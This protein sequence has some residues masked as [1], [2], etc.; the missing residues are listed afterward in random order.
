M[1][2]KVIALHT[3]DVIRLGRQ[4]TFKRWITPS[5]L[6]ADI[7]ACYQRP[8]GIKELAN[9]TQVMLNALVLSSALSKLPTNSMAIPF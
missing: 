1:V 6:F 9:G 4:L 8:H 5:V 7:V 2:S 3:K